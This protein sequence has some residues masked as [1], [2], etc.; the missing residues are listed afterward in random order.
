MAC[1]IYLYSSIRLGYCADGNRRTGNAAVT[2]ITGNVGI[3]T[4][5]PSQ[6]L[7][8]GSS[9]QFT[10]SSSGAMVA[11]SA[12]IGGVNGTPASINVSCPGCTSSEG[13][14]AGTYAYIGQYNGHNEYETSGG[15]V[16][17]NT[18]TG[19]WYFTNTGAI[20]SAVWYNNSG[21]NLPPNGSVWSNNGG[22]SGTLTTS[23]GG[24]PW[25]TIDS[26]GD[27]TTDGTLT[28]QGSGNSS[29][30]GSVGIGTTNP[31]TAL[32]VIGTITA[33]TKNFEIPYPG[34]EMP[35]Y[36]L[37]HST[38]EGPEVAVY[39]RGTANLVNGIATV[40]LPPYFGALTRAG[41][42][43]VYLTAKGSVPFTLSYDGFSHDEGTF[44]VH[45]NVQSGSFDWQVEATR[46][47]VPELQVVKPTPGK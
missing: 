14:P 42:E 37:V 21:S 15:L 38:I 27:I 47:D 32:Q 12:Q 18:G 13:N 24:N 39:Y 17:Y 28:I 34:G 1:Q 25:V 5:A 2:L 6:M 22:S 4:T 40:T 43:T 3:G 26:V 45:G 29:F 11:S 9:G 10:V 36:D 33:T 35:G 30:F 19:Y 41:S 31:T 7:T 46:A 20:G 23:N 44:I 8:V 16:L